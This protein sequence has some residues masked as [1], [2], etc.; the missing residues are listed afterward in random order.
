MAAPRLLSHAVAVLYPNDSLTA[1]LGGAINTTNP[2]VA[3]WWQDGNNELP[4]QSVRT[5]N[6]TSVVTLVSGPDGYVR[7]VAGI[8]VFNADA[9]AV[10]VT[11]ARVSGGVSYT[12]AKVTLDSGD[13]LIFDER[14]MI[15]LNSTGAAESVST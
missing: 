1:V 7:I 15:V 8:R 3:T 14:G 9:A 2:V 10:T 4:N 13:H 11:L 12:L 6:G 5:T